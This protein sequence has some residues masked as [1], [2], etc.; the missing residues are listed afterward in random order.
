MSGEGGGTVAAPIAQAVIA[1]WF[2][3]K[4]AREAGAEEDAAVLQQR[5][6]V[7]PMPQTGRP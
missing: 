6:A 1:K 4:R 5:T 2:E 3:K 7:A